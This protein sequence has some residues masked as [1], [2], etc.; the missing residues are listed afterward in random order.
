VPA[1]LRAGLVIETAPFWF[2]FAAMVPAT[3]AA[4]RPLRH[5]GAARQA[6][7]APVTTSPAAREAPT[8]G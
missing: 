3:A 2:A 6:G 4:W 8:D 5:L 7:A 1:L